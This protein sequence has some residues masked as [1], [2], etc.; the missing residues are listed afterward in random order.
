MVVLL[1]LLVVEGGVSAESE[2]VVVVV[3]GASK[4]VAGSMKSTPS[5]ERFAIRNSCVLLMRSFC[6]GSEAYVVADL[7]QERG[8]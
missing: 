1:L 6:H 5:Q 2:V 8:A 4:A 3:V 7:L